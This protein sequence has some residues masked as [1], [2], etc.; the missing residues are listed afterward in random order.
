MTPLNLRLPNTQY[1]IGSE[2][3]M[4][5]RSYNI[6]SSPQIVEK[7][8]PNAVRALVP[9]IL[10]FTAGT[11]GAMTTQGMEN[12]NLWVYAPYVHVERASQ[13]IDSLAPAEHVALIRDAF[14]LNM[15][16][17]AMVLGVSRPTVYAWLDGQEPKPEAL[18]DVQ[19]LSELAE[20]LQ[21]MK[22]TRVA[23]LVRRPIFN[24]RSLIDKL[25]AGEVSGEDLTILMEIAK[26]EAKSRQLTKGSGKTRRSLSD[27]SEDYSPA[28]YDRG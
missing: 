4:E 17:L 2:F 25:K 19:R 7:R 13:D 11:G 21:A 24:S 10:S 15:S 8:R 12:L 18:Q 27:V 1:L 20:Q 9:I 6:D 28:V 3:G 5:I 16:E 23:K 26:K 14:A 22:L